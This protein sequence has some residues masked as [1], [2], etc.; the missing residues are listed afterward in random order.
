MA[1]LRSLYKDSEVL[2]AIELATDEKGNVNYNE[3]AKILSAKPVGK[4]ITRQLA[5]Y[6][7]GQF[8]TTKKN[9][10]YYS[11]LLPENKRIKE[12]RSLRTPNRYEDLALELLPE[13]DNRS[14]LVIP[15][16]HAPY[17]HPDT[18][19][20][21]SAVAAKYRPDCVVHLGDEADK[22]A[23]S[24]HDSD[25]NLDSAGVE[26]EK[27]RVF[28]RKLHAMF[29]VMRICHSNHGSLHFRKANA[30]GIPVQ[31]LRTYRE[32]FFPNGGGERWEWKHSHTL[33]LPNGEQVTF[34][35]QPAGAVLADAAHERTNLVCGH[36]HGKMSIEYASNS[37]E[38]YW[39]A[40]GGC[41][42][43]E[44][45]LAFAYG[46]ESK[47]KPAL[48]CMVILEGVPHIIPMQTNSDGMW[49]GV[50]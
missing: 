2:S 8:K 4:K 46:K 1:K 48:G 38:Q 18:F 32:V 40:Q 31:Y 27:A 15:D 14:I 16:T 47:Y 26:L 49:T 39:A 34:K 41:L 6:W 25:P 30:H 12:Q 43:D 3:M 9:G 50:I 37:H 24:F 23:M 44:G 33:E 5:R 42:I 11:T 45:S 20:F 22:H 10:D 7:H 17:E 13:S 29:P 28:M 19:N 21:L 36:L 35:H